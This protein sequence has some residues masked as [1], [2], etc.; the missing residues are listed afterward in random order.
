LFPIAIKQ[1]KSSAEMMRMKPKMDIIQKKYKKDQAKLQAEMSKLYQE[2]GYNPLSGCLP[3]LVQ[4]PILYG[5]IFV[6]YSPLTYILWYSKDKV[7]KIK[8]ILWPI[9]H[10]ANPKVSLTDMRIELYI[11]K[12]MSGHMDQLAFLGNIKPIDFR[13]FGI[14]LSQN[15]GF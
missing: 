5:I 14:D 10:A 4:L 7:S 1:Q 13:I 9:I 3:M 2:E 8:T 12:A 15:P 11:A 6:V